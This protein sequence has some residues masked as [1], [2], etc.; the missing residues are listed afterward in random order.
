MAKEKSK[1]KGRVKESKKKYTAKLVNA[2]L[3]CW[4]IG[5]LRFEI[6]IINDLLYLNMILNKI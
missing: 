4:C 5:D 3:K 1:E 6:L 2:S